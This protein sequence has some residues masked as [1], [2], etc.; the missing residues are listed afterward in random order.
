MSDPENPNQPLLRAPSQGTAANAGEGGNSRRSSRAYKIAGLTLLACVLIVGQAMIAYF[1]LS[2]R[3]DIKSLEEQSNSLKT[4]LGEGRSVAGPMQMHVPIQT[5]TLTDDSVEEDSST[6]AP[7]RKVPMLGTSCWME[8]SGQMP[9]QV[10]G[11]RPACDENGQYK[12]EQCFHNECWCVNPFNGKQVP[13]SLRTGQR[14]KCPRATG[15]PRTLQ[16]Q[17]EVD[18]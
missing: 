13:G 4:Q 7:E 16:A 10:P 11:F 18:V 6:G 17:T 5:L 14:V 15:G 8:L 1:L 12:V 9:V 2:Q 3:N